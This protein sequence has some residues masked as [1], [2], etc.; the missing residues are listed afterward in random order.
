M[1][2]F[3][4]RRRQN[5]EVSQR[6]R[7]TISMGG[8]ARDIGGLRE[9]RSAVAAAA[10]RQDHEGAGTRKGAAVANTK[11]LTS[12]AQMMFDEMC[13]GDTDEPLFD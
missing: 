3:E 11:P 13:G 12:T 8:K 2:G 4:W 10:R 5:E 1:A 7:R 9:R 6:S